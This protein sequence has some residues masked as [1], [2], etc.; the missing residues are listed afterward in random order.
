MWIVCFVILLETLP[1]NYPFRQLCSFAAAEKSSLRRGEKQ[2]H[3][4]CQKTAMHNSL[5]FRAAFSDG[6]LSVNIYLPAFFT[7][8]CFE[9]CGWSLF[10]KSGFNFSWRQTASGEKWGKRNLRASSW[11]T[12]SCC[13]AP[14]RFFAQMQ[15]NLKS[16]ILQVLAPS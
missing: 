13:F 3:S 9:K 16:T 10:M 5:L 1:N 11:I 12:K 8:K 14:E 7:S 15:C 6:N 2:K 4:Y